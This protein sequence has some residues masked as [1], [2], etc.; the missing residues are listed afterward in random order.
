MIQILGWT[1]VWVGIIL[2]CYVIVLGLEKR[3]R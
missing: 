3:Y 1:A 2:G